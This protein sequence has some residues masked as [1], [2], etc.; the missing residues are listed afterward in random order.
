[1]TRWFASLFVFGLAAFGAGCPSG[2]AAD[3]CTSDFDCGSEFRTCDTASGTCLCNDARG[4]DDNEVCNEFGFC[5]ANSGCLTNADCKTDGQGCEVEFCNVKTNQC[6]STCAC[7]P[8]AGEI[9]CA[10]DAQCPFDHICADLD[11]VCVP[12]CRE[13]G[14]C[15]LGSGC[16]KDSIT[17]LLG[18]CE[19][20]TCTANNQCGTGDICDLNTGLCQFDDRGPYCYSC[21]GGVASDD[22]GEPG[23]YCLTDSSDPTGQSSFCGVDCSQQ[24][25]CPFGYSCND[26]I[27][28]PQTL[29]FCN[30]ELCDIPDGETVGTCTATTPTVTCS[31][32][33]DCPLGP[34]GGTCPRYN[35]ACEPGGTCP[36]GTE[37]PTSGVCPPYGHC[38]VGQAPC[39]LDADCCEDEGECPE[40]SC[41]LQRCVG[42]EGDAF[43]HCTCTIDSDCPRDECNDEDL[44]DPENPILGNCGLSGHACYTDDDCDTI[45]CV[46]GGC[47]I[48]ANCAPSNDRNCRDL[49]D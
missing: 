15:R 8:A 39:E 26:V 47:R 38:L 21:T 16:V 27:I 6:E 22:C 10:V 1:M 42:G 20:G 30:V 9:C 45:A 37:C 4:C 35:Q 32:D 12:G 46:D 43:G 23:N 5:Q 40:G 2:S 44:S 24:Q 29:P 25:A 49:A 3:G 41:V 14:D 7:D 28:I 17:A 31:A 18:V 34:P 11:G 48:G 33:E 13:D 19:A 36:S